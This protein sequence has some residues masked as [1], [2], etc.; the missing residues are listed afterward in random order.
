M[1]NRIAALLMLAYLFYFV[2]EYIKTSLLPEY[3]MQI[4]LYG[5][6]P[7]LLF[8]I[9]FLVHLSILIGGSITE[10]LKR[11]L[12][13]V[14]AAPFI[15]WAIFL[16]AKDHRELY[17]ASI[18]DGRSPLDPLFLLLTIIFVAGYILMSVIILAVSWLR[19]HEAKL[20][21][22]ARSLLINLF[23]LFAWFVV[24]TSLLQSGVLTARYAM[25]LYFIGYL[26]WAVVLRHLI[27]KHNIMPDYRK[28][29]HIL[30]KSA[31]TAILLLDRSGTVKEMNPRANQWFEGIAVADIPSHFEFNNGLRLCELVTRVFQGQSN[32]SSEIRLTH[33]KQGQ[34]DLM[35]GLELIDGGNEE[36]FVMHLTDITSLKA[37]ERR[38][39]ESERSYKH[40]AHHDPLTDLYN[41]I[42]IQEQLEHRIANRESFALVLIDLNNFK[43]VNDTYGHLVGDLYL[44][45]IAHI[46]KQ[47]TA[48]GDV[49]GRVGGDEFVLIV[50]CSPDS[51]AHEQIG[52]LLEKGTRYAFLHEQTEIPVSFS[53]GVSVY[54]IDASDVTKLMKHADE[55]MY[56]VKRAGKNEEA[57]IRK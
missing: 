10:P 4:V 47:C 14:Y 18:T 27:G 48:P 50:P 5:N 41:R 42:A 9:C 32:V 33:L 12:P 28:L 54:P 29:F 44:K 26:T 49:A 19:T 22:I 34:L 45:H 25:I 7:M 1:V 51:D 36:L 16:L 24:V 30:F 39:L 40:L 35:M 53:A 8:V 23:S 6:S 57:L 13:I 46:L 37:T 20:R 17:D 3:Q 55:A 2:G 21:M 15:L 43:Q 31:P 56:A 38:L 11:W 52:R